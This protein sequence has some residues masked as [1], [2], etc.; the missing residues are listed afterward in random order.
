[1]KKKL[2]FIELLIIFSYFIIPPML[3][4]PSSTLSTTLQF[5]IFMLFYVAIAIILT[6]QF[7]LSKPP[8]H[9]PIF[10]LLLASI[11]TIIL[12]FATASSII[13]LT[14]LLGEK[15]I[16]QKITISFPTTF[17]DFLN[18]LLAIFSAAFYE[19]AIYRVFLPFALITLLSKDNTINKHYHIA[20]EVFSILCFALGHRYLGLAAVINAVIC[21]IILRFCFLYTQNPLYSTISHSIYNVLAVILSSL[22]VKIS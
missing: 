8:L 17:F 18:L 5:S 10:K 12:L 6:V 3:K 22:F 20:I 9:K 1:M 13:V 2:I 15:S 14:S 11:F 21:G 4:S 7:F 19:E 16:P